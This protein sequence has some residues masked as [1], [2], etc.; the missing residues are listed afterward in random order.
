MPADGGKSEK[1]LGLSL[2]EQSF[3]AL[4][5]Y[6]TRFG[7]GNGWGFRGDHAEAGRHFHL[8]W[9]GSDIKAASTRTISLTGSSI[10]S[11]TILVNPSGSTLTRN[12]LRRPL[13][14]GRN[15]PVKFS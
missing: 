4:K 7:V 11:L 10:L 3:L 2:G 9:L 5:P 6:A 14:I 12:D 13:L 1:S 15:T 8:L